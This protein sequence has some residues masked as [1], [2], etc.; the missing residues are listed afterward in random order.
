MESCKKEITV[1]IITPMFSCGANKGKPEFRLTEL[2]A[3]MRYWW[4]ACNCFSNIEEMKK[5]EEQLFGS[6]N[7][8]SPFILRY[9]K[10]QS[11]NFEEKH[12][13]SYIIGKAIKANEKVTFS[14]QIRNGDKKKTIEEYKDMIELAS[15]LGGIGRFSRK[16]QGVFEICGIKSFIDKK[17]LAKRVEELLK[18][19]GDEKC[20]INCQEEEEYISLELNSKRGVYEYPYIEEIVIG[21]PIQIVEFYRKRNNTL[22]KRNADKANVEFKFNSRRYACPVYITCYPCANEKNLNSFNIGKVYPILVFLKNTY[23]E[24][25]CDQEKYIKFKEICKDQMLI[26]RKKGDENNNGRN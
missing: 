16:G 17:D 6:T 2:K 5:Q 21:K 23:V 15:I 12:D 14:L 1:K 11:P 13:H 20:K 10:K 19:V 26:N 18:K 4:R 9:Y 3:S 8:I 22:R 7:N 25:E 24:N